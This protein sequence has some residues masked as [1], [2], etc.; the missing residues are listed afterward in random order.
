MRPQIDYYFSVLSDWA[1]LGG[2]RLEQIAARRGVLINYRPV[3]LAEIYATTGGVLL[4]QR[5]QQRQAYRE[6]ELKRWRAR[7][8]M[9]LVIHPRHYPTDDVLASCVIIAAAEAGAEPGRIANAILRAIWAEERDIADPAD[10]RRILGECGEDPDL[11]MES[12]AD[13]RRIE[14][15]DRNTRE[16]ATRGVFGSPFYFHDGEIFWGQDRLDWLE[17]VLARKTLSPG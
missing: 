7:L 8:D 1:Y 5:S 9:P 17:E 6:V 4:Q 2:E 16:A 15:L 3:R 10:L 14:I 13:P 11:L 12:A